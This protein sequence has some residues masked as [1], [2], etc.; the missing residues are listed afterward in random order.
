MKKIQ[1]TLDI[2]FNYEKKKCYFDASAQSV[3]TPHMVQLTNC[4]PP[5]KN[6]FYLL[7]IKIVHL[8]PILIARNV[9]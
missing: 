5:R 3:C 8:K 2:R 6:I 4:N 9:P 1:I 7:A